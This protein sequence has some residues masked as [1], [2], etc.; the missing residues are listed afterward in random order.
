MHGFLGDDEDFFWVADE[1][2]VGRFSEFFTGV[3]GGYY[4]RHVFVRDIGGI[5]WEGDR[6]VGIGRG[7]SD[8]EPKVTVESNRVSL[9]CNLHGQEA[10]IGW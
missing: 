1:P 3:D 8:E 9:A 7:Y 5:D 2:A 10:S 6:L 4:D